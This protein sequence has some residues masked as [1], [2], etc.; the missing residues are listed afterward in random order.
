[1]ARQVTS[2]DPDLVRI[3]KQR[4]G[5]GHLK[6]PHDARDWQANGLLGAARNLPSEASLEPFVR[7]VRD[8]GATESCVGN[9]LAQAADVRL[10]RLGF[11]AP[12]VSALAIYTMA[13]DLARIDASEPIV[14]QGSYARLAFKAARSNGFVSEERWPLS[15]D[16]VNDELP[17]DVLQAGSAFKV[18]SWYRIASSG[19]SRAQEVCNAI[20]Q[21][22]PVIF[23]AQVDQPFMDFV[24]KGRVPMYDPAQAVGGHMLC[25]VGYAT[26]GPSKAFRVVNSWGEGWGDHGFFWADEGWVTA[27][28][29]DDVYVVQIAGG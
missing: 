24:G 5:T 9:A 12:P 11:S 1:M 6:D 22:W 16:H 17:W 18:A 15:Q 2:S 28:T 19:P 25:L 14:D 3:A 21:G 29:V 10:N 13:R 8:Q 20:A 4:F 27:D 7:H 26:D 23:A